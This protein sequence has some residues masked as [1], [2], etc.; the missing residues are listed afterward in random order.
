MLNV[1]ENTDIHT[2]AKHLEEHLGSGTHG[3]TDLGFSTL[4]VTRR[5]LT[6]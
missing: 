6:G 1:K 5:G 4:P 2:F 3:P